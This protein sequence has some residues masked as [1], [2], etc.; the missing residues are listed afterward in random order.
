MT[1]G[2][3]LAVLDARCVRP[4]RWEVNGHKVVRLHASRRSGGTRKPV[5]GVDTPRSWLL[6]VGETFD[7][8]VGALVH[9][10]GLEGIE[11]K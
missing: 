11:V 3:L 2:R 10:A 5:W 9:V 8:F 7:S 1:R 6:P 4:G